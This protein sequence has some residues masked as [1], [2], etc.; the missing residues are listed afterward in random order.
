MR[1]CGFSG[2]FLSLI[3][4]T[5]FILLSAASVQ[6]EPAGVSMEELDIDEFFPLYDSV[7]FQKQQLVIRENGNGKIC[8]VK[9][10]FGYLA[11]SEASTVNLSIISTSIDRVSRSEAYIRGEIKNLDDK[12][13]DTLVITFNLFNANGDQ[14]GNAYASIDYLGPK[15]TWKFTT[16]LIDRSDFQF[17]RYASIYAGVFT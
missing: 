9:R 1:L 15:K 8:Y 5:F 12:V 13:I 10:P 16:D 11:S 3:P 14:I 2:L 17:E 6:A 4:V 7:N